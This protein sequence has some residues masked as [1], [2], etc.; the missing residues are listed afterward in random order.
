M[1]GLNISCGSFSSEDN[2]GTP[3]ERVIDE[4][5][6]VPVK[7]KKNILSGFDTDEYT[8]I[9][10]ED[11]ELLIPALLGYRSFLMAEIGHDNWMREIDREESTGVCSIKLKWGEGRGWRLYCAVNLLAACQESAKTRQPVLVSLA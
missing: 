2:A 7:I 5:S 11:A 6:G 10:P 3:F 1:S 9:D 4:L 8:F